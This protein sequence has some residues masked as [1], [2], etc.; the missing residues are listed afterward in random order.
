VHLLDATGDVALVPCE[1]CQGNVRKK[2]AVHVC[3]LHGE[4][5]PT[6][7]AAA[8]GVLPMKCALCG[9]N[10]ANQKRLQHD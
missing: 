3:A 10:P 8:T 4:C 6:A 7:P 5:L 1:T 9:H 2:H